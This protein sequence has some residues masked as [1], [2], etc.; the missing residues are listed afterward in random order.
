[1][2]VPARRKPGA[3]QK[4]IE[5]MVEALDAEIGAT[6]RHRR[7]DWK[8][9]GVGDRVARS[10][11]GAVYAFQGLRHHSYRAGTLLRLKVAGA[12]VTA[13]VVGHHDGVL[14]LACPKDVG[15]AFGP[16][17]AYRDP[18]W[19]LVAQRAA[20]R[21]LGSVPRLA[22]LLL[23]PSRART[24]AATPD[25]A[26]SRG[27]ANLNDEQSAAIRRAVGSELHYL[28]GPP[29]TGKTRTLAGAAEALYRQ[30]ESVLLVAPTNAAVDQLLLAV[31]DRLAGDPVLTSGQVLR[32][33][34]IRSGGL[35]RRF[36][37]HVDLE[38]A[39]RARTGG[40]PRPLAGAIKQALAGLVNASP[41][42]QTANELR[43]RL[44]SDLRRLQNQ[45]G[46]RQARRDRVRRQLLGRAQIVA[47]TLHLAHL[48]GQ[49]DRAFD[50]VVIDEASAATFPLVFVASA[51][52]ARNRVI[53]GGDFRQLP[54]VVKSR[55]PN[56]RRW[57]GR[58]AFEVGGLASGGAKERAPGV[59]ST[60]V[61]QYRMHPTICRVVS[62]YAY[63]GRLETAESRARQPWNSSLLVGEDPV[64][65]IDTSPFH[66]VLASGGRP[67]ANPVHG[68]V[69]GRLLTDLLGGGKET[70]APS[71][72]V[73][74]PYRDQVRTH[75]ER[76]G[77]TYGADFLTVHKAQG[78]EWDVV[79]LDLPSAPGVAPSPF[80][81]ATRWAE[82]G[83]RL[84]NVGA[85]R[86]REQ[87]IVVADCDYYDA[88][89]LGD[90]CVGRL[91]SLLEEEG[92]RVSCH[93]AVR[94]LPDSG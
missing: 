8:A 25:P 39:V 58:D 7:K 49:L 66:T 2:A 26:I 5:Q 81:Q 30:G 17:R 69:V 63:A 23:D 56:A 78:Q 40:A 51:L 16:A 52:R 65:L 19:L 75:R 53:V 9:I 44:R 46:K 45:S 88:H 60:L 10:S 31:C 35:K 48:P 50:A 21:S 55:D 71:V 11:T 13:R 86:A 76:F 57:L 36:G 79:I 64:L 73:L 61:R 47:T 43:R 20:L 80:A 1:M 27:V 24:G 94:S 91:L 59:L 41:G 87:L 38:R 33:G 18:S 3:P 74:S 12:T 32:L 22:T 89:D 93:Q 28:W 15:P 42:D 85:S 68:L 6:R 70:V 83:S 77:A 67:R 14:T 72:A 62:R 34:R 37:R 92:R 90:A 29:G 54:P 4:A 84:K 82:A